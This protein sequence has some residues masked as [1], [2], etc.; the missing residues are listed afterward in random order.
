M[1]RK[2]D[3]LES[4]YI[5][6]NNELEL[7]LI[8]YEEAKDEYREAYSDFEL[9]EKLSKNIREK[10]LETY[11]E[12]KCKFE[13]I[14]IEKEKALAKFELIKNEYEQYNTKFSALETEK[15]DLLKRKKGVNEDKITL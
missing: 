2:R 3:N 1:S 8:D 6:A 11:N 5:K 12:K 13:E 7:F 14:K 4:N 15:E 10:I 9:S